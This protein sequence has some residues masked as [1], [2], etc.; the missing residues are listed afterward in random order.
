[1]SSS[2]SWHSLLTGAE[3]LWL[4]T[5]KYQLRFSFLFLACKK[6]YEL[7]M[8]MKMFFL[9][10]NSWFFSTCWSL[11]RA[12]TSSLLWSLALF[13]LWTM[14]NR[15]NEIYIIVSTMQASI[16]T[17]RDNGTK[18]IYWDETVAHKLVSSFPKAQNTSV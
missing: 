14:S 9:T 6:N 5:A 8:D 11:Q 4:L 16:L 10:N 7:W 15:V 1:M 2:S 17:R 13:I 3:Q 12:L 18:R